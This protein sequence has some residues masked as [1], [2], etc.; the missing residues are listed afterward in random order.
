MRRSRISEGAGFI[1]LSL[2]VISLPTFGQAASSASAVANSYA[3]ITNATVARAQLQVERVRAMVAAGTLPRKQLEEAETALADAQDEAILTRTLYGGTR[4]QDLSPDQVKEMVAA[5]ERRVARWQA[6]ATER[7]QLVQEG[8]LARNEAQPVS[9]EL[10]MRR[11]TLQLAQERARLL[12]EL[13]AMAETERLA[14]QSRAEELN[15]ARNV[16]IRFEGAGPFSLQIFKNISSAYW[17]QFRQDLPVSALGQTLVHQ[18]LGFDHRGRVDIALNPDTKEGL[19][20]RKLLESRHI[21]YIA[22]R[23]AL[24]GSATGPH[25]HIGAGSLRVRTAP[26]PD[27]QTKGIL[28][29]TASTATGL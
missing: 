17:A 15:A 10:E 1:F 12:N 9:D 14:E 8:V 27:A 5:A 23:S 26:P 6:K 4:V 25:I 21:S 11:K 2:F 22:F 18:R 7:M 16:M 24:S 28:A 20:L 3:Q 29:Q 19:W 13:L